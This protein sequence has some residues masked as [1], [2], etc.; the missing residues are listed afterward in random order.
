MYI[1]RVIVLILMLIALSGYLNSDKNYPYW[2]NIKKSLAFDVSKVN[3]KTS[4]TSRVLDIN[5]GIKVL[6]KNH[7]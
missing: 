2:Q 4:T 5:S 7:S 3:N 1:L 6:F